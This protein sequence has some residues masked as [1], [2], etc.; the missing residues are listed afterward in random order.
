[1]QSDHACMH[2]KLI[3]YKIGYQKCMIATNSYNCLWNRGTLLSKLDHKKKKKKN[4]S[5]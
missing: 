1:M 2:A 5:I 3:D 4:V